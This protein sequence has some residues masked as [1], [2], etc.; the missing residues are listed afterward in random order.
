MET[1]KLK[2]I[3]KKLI[4]SMKPGGLNSKA[5]SN[6]IFKRFMTI[7]TIM[8]ISHKML[9]MWNGSKTGIFRFN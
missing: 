8:R 7:L 6:G 3:V 5:I 4:S 2:A 1:I 9:M